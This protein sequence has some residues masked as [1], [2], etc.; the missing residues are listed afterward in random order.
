MPSLWS[1]ALR[2]EGGQASV[3]LVAAVPFVLL[4]AA[5]AWQLALAGQTAWLC[6]NAARVAARAEA[7]GRDARA[8]ALSALPKPFRHGLEV[9]RPSDGRTVRVRIRIPLLVRRWTSP[10][11]VSASAGLPRGGP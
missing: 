3:E 1:R 8:A 5:I 9:S 2:L 7:V 4:A 11:T 6:A 10:V